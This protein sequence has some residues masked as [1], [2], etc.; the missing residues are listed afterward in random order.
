MECGGDKK[1]G[2]EDDSYISGLVDTKDWLLMEVQEK[3]S[4]SMIVRIE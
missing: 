2:T 3:A 1:R 4:T